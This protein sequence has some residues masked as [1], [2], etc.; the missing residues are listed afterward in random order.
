[1]MSGLKNEKLVNNT[2]QGLGKNQR[3]ERGRKQQNQTLT[4]IQ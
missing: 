1:M 2:M 4:R 3:K